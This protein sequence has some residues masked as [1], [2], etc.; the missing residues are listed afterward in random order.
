MARSAMDFPKPLS[1]KEGKR[2]MGFAQVSGRRL[3]LPQ[4]T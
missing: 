4:P 1:T 2:V 3:R